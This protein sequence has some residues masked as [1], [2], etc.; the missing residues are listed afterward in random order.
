MKGPLVC[1]V[2]AVIDTLVEL[3]LPEELARDLVYKWKVV[4]HPAAIALKTDP[5]LQQ[6]QVWFARLAERMGLHVLDTVTC[7][8]PN[9][10]KGPRCARMVDHKRPASRMW[11][12]I[13]ESSSVWKIR[14]NGPS[15]AF[16]ITCSPVCPRMISCLRYFRHTMPSV[17]ARI[18]EGYLG[19]DYGTFENADGVMNEDNSL[20]TW[21][22]HAPTDALTEYLGGVSGWSTDEI[23]QRTR[24][25]RRAYLLRHC[26]RF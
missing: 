18:T 11:H 25:N 14:T 16:G 1:R 19:L 10:L 6:V 23:D 5:W 20:A 4:E 21:L 15:F 26:M 2:Q 17:D 8:C 24:G 13:G 3:G 9:K 22:R 12:M 7:A